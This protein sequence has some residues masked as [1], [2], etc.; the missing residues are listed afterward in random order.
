MLTLTEIK[1]F[2]LINQLQQQNIIHHI[3]VLMNERVE[4][5]VLNI[6]MALIR[7]RFTALVPRLL[8]SISGWFRS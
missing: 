8:T 6:I 4:D 5:S 7:I 2:F 3:H 1:H